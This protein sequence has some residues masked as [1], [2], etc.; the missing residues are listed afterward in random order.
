MKRLY[1][2]LHDHDEI[3]FKLNQVIRKLKKNASLFKIHNNNTY[4][5]N[6]S[7]KIIKRK[8]SINKATALPP[9]FKN[10]SFVAV[11]KICTQRLPVKV[12]HWPCLVSAG[13]WISITRNIGFNI[14]SNRC[15]SS[16][17]FYHNK[18]IPNLN[19][20]WSVLETFTLHS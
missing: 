11:S 10:A 19:H 5:E 1:I 7:F 6:Q 20:F 8:H 2:L 17:I 16:A 9:M 18:Q 15:I 3:S 13:L 12:I 4:D 14:P